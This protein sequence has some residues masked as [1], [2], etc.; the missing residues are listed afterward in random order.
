MSKKSAIIVEQLKECLKC[1]HP[2]RCVKKER[3]EWV[4]SWSN[5]GVSGRI[6]RYVVK[7]SFGTKERVHV[8]CDTW[9][10]SRV[11]IVRSGWATM[12]TSGRKSC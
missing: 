10:G 1:I 5:K 11:L 6:W 9:R 4:S 12:R 3:L 7:S 8:S 2:C